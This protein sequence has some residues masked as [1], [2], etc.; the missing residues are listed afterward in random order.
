MTTDVYVVDFVDVD[1]SG[2]I[3]EIVPRIR[4]LVVDYGRP[5]DGVLSYDGVAFSAVV[6]TGSPDEALL[7]ADLLLEEYLKRH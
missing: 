4:D 6:R 7:E 3:V 1:D 2:A 5:D